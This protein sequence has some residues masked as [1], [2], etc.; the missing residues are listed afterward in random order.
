MV[1][2]T[3]VYNIYK[4]WEGNRGP[5][6]FELYFPLRLLLIAV[7][8]GSFLLAFYYLRDRVLLPL[9]YSTSNSVMGAPWTALLL[10]LVLVSVEVGA[11]PVDPE[12]S[13]QRALAGLHVRLA[14]V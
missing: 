5:I 11:T 8:V 9:R 1:A 14:M 6:A 10:S 7:L 13:L 2:T 4:P 12:I 3:H